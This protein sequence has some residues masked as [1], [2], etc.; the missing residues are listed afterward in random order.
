MIGPR[1][2]LYLEKEIV[3]LIQFSDH[4]TYKC[5]L[6]REQVGLNI[7]L[8]SKSRNRGINVYIVRRVHG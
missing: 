6:E 4:F 8:C 7:R 5:F 3:K 2:I 1:F